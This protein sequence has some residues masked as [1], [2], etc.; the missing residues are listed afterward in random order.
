MQTKNATHIK[1]THS[2]CKPTNQTIIQYNTIQIQNRCECLDAKH[3]AIETNRRAFA[4][5]VLEKNEVIAK[6][7]WF[8]LEQ[9]YT[10]FTAD[11]YRPLGFPSMGQPPPQGQFYCG[12]GIDNVFGRH[13]SECHLFACIYC[14][15]DISGTN[16]EV[17]PGSWEY[18]IGPTLGIDCADQ[19]WIARYIMDRIAEEFKVKVNIEPKPMPKGDW[20]G[21]GCHC[22]FS[23]NSMRSAREDENDTSGGIGEIYKC[24]EYLETSH[25]AH[26][27]LYGVGNEMRMTGAHETAR[28]DEFTWGIGMFY[29]CIWFVL[30]CTLYFVWFAICLT[31]CLLICCVCKFVF[32]CFFFWCVCLFDC[33]LCVLWK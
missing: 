13:V 3:D 16:A 8:G 2:I 11:S 21:S 32:V 17:M 14:D 4:R 12:T 15:L 18:Q 31:V 29:I 30:F 10:L 27:E 20:N 33:D 24:M 28:F 19:L 26:M 1:K 22:N 9:E 23:T 5:E 6:E 7:P 25:I